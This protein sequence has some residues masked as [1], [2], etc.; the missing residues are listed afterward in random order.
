MKAKPNVPN[1]LAQDIL[2]PFKLLETSFSVVKKTIAV[3][4]NSYNNNPITC[5]EQADRLDA[6]NNIEN[7]M[8]AIKKQFAINNH[9]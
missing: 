5:K 1:K 6:Q 3:K 8:Q 2:S 4:I 9:I 7:I